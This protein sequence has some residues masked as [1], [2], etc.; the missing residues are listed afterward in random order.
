MNFAI[1]AHARVTDGGPSLTPELPDG[2]AEPPFGAAP[3]RLIL[4]RVLLRHLPEEC[5]LEVPN[6]KTKMLKYAD[7]WP[8]T[9]I[10]QTEN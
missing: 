5:R 9:F 8:V 2:A 7:R 10:Q 3:G 1:M 6:I 4:I